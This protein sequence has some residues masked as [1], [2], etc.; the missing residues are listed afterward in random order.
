MTELLRTDGL[1]KYFGEVHA[2]DEVNVSFNEGIITSIIGPNGA[3]KTT[4][5]NVL[6]GNILPDSGKVFFKGEDITRLPTHSRIR[7]GMSRS[8]QIMNIFGRLTVFNNILIPVLSTLNKTL[9]AYSQLSDQRDAI[10]E[11]ERILEVVGLWDKKDS[12]AGQLSHGDQRLLEL[13]IAIATKPEL[14]FL[15]EP[16]SGMNP[17]ERVTVLETIKKLS[18]EKETTFVIIEHDMDVVFFLSD[19]IVVMNRGKI[20]ADGNPVQIRENK[21]VREIY[22]GEEI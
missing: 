13:G 1:K 3:G 15:D 11:A 19:R 16:T 21:E 6:T 20:L 12:L 22:L 17:V 4:L 5:I 14:C 10:T 18:A 2:V 7:K 8:F 9:R